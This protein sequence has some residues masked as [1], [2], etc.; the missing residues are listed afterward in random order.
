MFDGGF[1]WMIM[2]A[3]FVLL[4]IGAPIWAKDLGFV[5]TKVKW[6]ISIIWYLFLLLTIAAPLTA[7]AENEAQAAFRMGLVLLVITVVTGVGLFR[8]LKHVPKTK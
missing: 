2:G 3:L 7:L 5:M 1:F 4:G 8:Y 6:T